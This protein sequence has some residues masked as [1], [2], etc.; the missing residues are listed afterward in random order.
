SPALSKK[1]S[2]ENIPRSVDRERRSVSKSRS[3]TPAPIM[4]PPEP[5]SAPPPLQLTPQI[6]LGPNGEMILD[7]AS[8]V[9][10]N[11]REK[12]IR[13][14]LAKAEIVYMDEFSG[15][16]GYYSRYKRTRDWPPEETIRFYR[17]LHTIGTDFSMMIQLFPNRTRRDLK[18]KF[19][20]EERLNLKLVN[21]A[22]L[23]PKEFN[24]EELRQQF[25][26]ED[27]EIERQREQERQLNQSKNRNPKKRPRRKRR[28]V[29][30]NES[31]ADPVVERKRSSTAA[32]S[33]PLSEAEEVEDDVFDGN[34]VSDSEP[35]GDTS[36]REDRVPQVE[37]IPYIPNGELDETGVTSVTESSQSITSQANAEVESSDSRLNI[38]AM[39]I[40]VNNPS[41][42]MVLP[43][44]TTPSS[45]SLQ[46]KPEM[47][48]TESPTED[49]TDWQE[50]EYSGD[51]TEQPVYDQEADEE[52]PRGLGPLEDIDIN[53]L[54]LVESQDT[55]D[56]TKTI[57]E[58]YVTDPETGKLSEKPLDVPYDVIEN[59]RS[60]LEGGE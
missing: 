56:P 36:N 8:L 7:E 23:Y 38:E 37:S 51:Q 48:S 32:V 54:V 1:G 17:C 30:R 40:E 47:E 4:A 12:A 60:I 46:M 43:D 25:E 50:S 24:I 35:T 33:K 27:E 13:D 45:D 59:I 29:T 42:V 14:S 26:E 15:N 44:E 18:L 10:E 34:N 39:D 2:M 55:N 22:L 58:I 31:A 57:Y 11:E 20:K 21:K 9:V 53:S 41:P 3:P 52:E 5:P 19:K 16:S 28:K 49:S 6:K